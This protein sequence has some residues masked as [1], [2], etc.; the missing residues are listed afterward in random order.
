MKYVPSDVKLLKSEQI[1]A[2][3]VLIKFVAFMKRNNIDVVLNR[4]TA[5]I[6]DRF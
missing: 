1:H 3:L 2:Y 5:V 4:V 6:F